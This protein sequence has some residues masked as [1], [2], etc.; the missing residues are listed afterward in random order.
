MVGGIQWR[1]LQASTCLSIFC[2]YHIAFNTI[3][4]YCLLL[5]RA[6]YQ[7]LSISLISSVQYM[8]CFASTTQAFSVLLAEYLGLHTGSSADHG[9]DLQ[10]DRRREP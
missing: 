9:P 10:D 2:I 3:C 1:Y 7:C 6:N 5:L 8:N 4:E